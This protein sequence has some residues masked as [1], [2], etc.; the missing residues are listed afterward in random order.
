M[1]RQVEARDYVS[2]FATD[3]VF[4]ATESLRGVK[5]VLE[6]LPVFEIWR[7]VDEIPEL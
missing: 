4:R 2:G 6:R 5:N 1:S 7:I 3:I